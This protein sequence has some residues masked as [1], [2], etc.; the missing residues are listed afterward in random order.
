MPYEQPGGL[1]RGGGVGGQQRSPTVTVRLRRPPGERL[2]MVLS[3]NNLTRTISAPTGV[4]GWTKL[5]TV[6]ASTMSTT[7]WT[8]VVEPGDPA[9]W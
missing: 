8:K 4:T 9:T 3:I 5:D 6:T 1:R 7:A 2:L